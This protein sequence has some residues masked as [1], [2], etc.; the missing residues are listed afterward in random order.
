MTISPRSVSPEGKASR[1]ALQILVAAIFGG[2]LLGCSGCGGEAGATTVSS[3]TSSAGGAGGIPTTTTLFGAGATGGAGGEGPCSGPLPPDVPQGWV[4]PPGA[5]CECDLFV[6]PN[7]DEARPASPWASCGTGCEELVVDWTTD[8]QYRFFLHSGIADGEGNRYVSYTRYLDG[9]GGAYETQIVHLPSNAVVFD[10][11]QQPYLNGAGNWYGGPYPSTRAGHLIEYAQS[12]DKGTFEHVSLFYVAPLLEDAYAPLNVTLDEVVPWGALEAAL[13]EEL[14][15][16]GYQGARAWGWHGIPLAPGMNPGWS[17]PDS[18]TLSSLAAS[19]TTVLFSTFGVAA[20]LLAWTADNGVQPL[21]SYPSTSAGGACGP[22]VGA[23][24]MVWTEC[25]TLV[26]G[27]E[28][29]SC[30]LMASPIASSAAGLAPRIVRPAYS[31][32]VVACGG[33][34]GGGYLLRLERSSAA[35]ESKVILTRLSDGH[36]WVLT[37]EPGFTYSHMLYVD[38]TELALG[39]SKTSGT[40]TIHRL[41]IASLGP[42][43]PPGSGF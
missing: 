34:M 2:A 18:R 22:V 26:Q 39:L 13:S 15:A 12:L 4:R 8:E 41:Q 37:P 5:P 27:N 36:Y 43:L 40:W 9:H 14:W 3:S 29:A 23:D 24:E 6:A 19:G 17:S 21:V 33:V 1:A 35:A 28:Y 7:A 16:I 42:P 32:N 10:A 31:D 20:E 38:D 25:Q 30:S 11:I